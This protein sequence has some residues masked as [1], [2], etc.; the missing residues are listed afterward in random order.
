M[1]TVTGPIA[2]PSA[3]VPALGAGPLKSDVKG[4]AVHEGR[5][6][7]RARHARPE[8]FHEGM[9]D[10]TEPSLA[11]VQFVGSRLALMEGKSGVRLRA[12]WPGRCGN[13]MLRSGKFA[14]WEGVAGG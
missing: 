5:E 6:P 4:R 2:G 9:I 14:P 3:E 10:T 11:S 1:T 13:R 7:F 8:G 12:V